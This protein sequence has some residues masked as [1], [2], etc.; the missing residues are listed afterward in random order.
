MHEL[1]GLLQRL[2]AMEGAQSRGLDGGAI[3]HG[4]GEGHAEF[5]DVGPGLGQ[6]LDDLQRCLVVG[7]A[8]GH[9]GHQRGAALLFQFGETAFDAARHNFTPR[10]SATVKISLS[11]RP[12]IFITIKWSLG[13][14]G[15]IFMTW[16]SAWEGSRAGMMPSSLQQS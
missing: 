16:A 9:K 12:H 5:N 10:I 15:A 3:G 4:I 14:V 13:L 6:A 11:P 1:Q 7:I 8:G 2:P